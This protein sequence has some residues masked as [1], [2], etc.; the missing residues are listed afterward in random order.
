MRGEQM[1]SIQASQIMG[2][3][4]KKK[5]LDVTC[6]S[7]TIWFDKQHPAQM[8]IRFEKEASC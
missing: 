7:R 2:G 5:I 6:G 1:S 3:N 4:G 8:K